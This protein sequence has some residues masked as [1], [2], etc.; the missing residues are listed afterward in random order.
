MNEA[1]LASLS[2]HL[3]CL[4][5]SDNTNSPHGNSRQ[6]KVRQFTCTLIIVFGVLSMSFEAL[7]LNRE[8]VEATRQ[9]WQ[10]GDKVAACKALLEYYRSCSS[11]HWLRQSKEA[12]DD[13]IEGEANGR[14]VR[15]DDDILVSGHSIVDRGHVPRRNDGHLDWTHQGP[16]NDLQFANH[17]NR[18]G[19][20]RV[21]LRAHKL[22]DKEDYIEKLDKNLRDWRF[23]PKSSMPY[24]TSL[25][26][27]PPLDC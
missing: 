17:L 14:A 3:R 2:E 13:A 7:D 27:H 11:G 8:G 22:T 19:H 6:N 16:E 18:H 25:P 9:A 24:R 1:L 4:S 21:L 5:V 20:L 12:N 10:L 26:S 15:P 23:G